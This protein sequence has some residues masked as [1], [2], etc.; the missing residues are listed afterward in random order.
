MYKYYLG[1]LDETGSYITYDYR[2]IK[3]H[4]IPM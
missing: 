1:S 3:I 2:I 4:G